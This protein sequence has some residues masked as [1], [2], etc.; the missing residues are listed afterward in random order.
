MNKIAYIISVYKDPK[1]LGRLIRALNYNA[2]FYIHC[3]KKVNEKPFRKQVELFDNVKFIEK[4][5]IVNWG[6]FAQVKLQK[7]LMKA[8]IDSK[9]QY[10]KVVCLSGMDYPIWPNQKI[11]SEFINNPDK[12]YI[13]GMNISRKIMG[14]EQNK[15]I[16][17]YHFRDITIKNKI[18][19][20]FISGTLKLMNNVLPI[21]KAWY[22]FFNGHFS[23]VFLG[24]DYWALSLSC[25]KLVYNAMC[26]EKKLMY[27]FKYSFAP[28][29]MCIQTNENIIN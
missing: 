3:D 28:S 22:V 9:I 1:Q 6:S 15:R 14:K 29:E 16:T 5:Y 2:D 27:Y 4:R 21:R 23:N 12:N 26:V 25:V 20:M 24:S 11:Q 17:K 13:I 8:V 7:E 10:L 18:V 19:K